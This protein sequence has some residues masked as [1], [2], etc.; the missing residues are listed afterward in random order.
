M[1]Q[2]CAVLMFALLTMQPAL[3][4]KD[5]AGLPSSP[6][7]GVTKDRFQRQP[8]LQSPPAGT[9][10]SCA[11]PLRQGCEAQQASCRIACPPMWSTNPG[12]PAF[13]P[14][15]RAGCTQ[16]CFSRYLSCLQLYGC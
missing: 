3:A 10:R 12:A 15:D 7:P 5:G 11:Q 14:T 1:R 9:P 16:R 13:T 2:L 8:P 4:A 6:R